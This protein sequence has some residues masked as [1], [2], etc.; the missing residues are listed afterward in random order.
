MTKS[1]TDAMMREC[2]LDLMKKAL[3]GALYAESAWKILEHSRTARNPE[4]TSVMHP[5]RLIHAKF[6]DMMIAKLR[7]KSL[8]LVE[9]LPFDKKIREC[10]YDWPMIGYTMVGTKRLGNVQRCFAD[11]IERGVPGDLAETGAWRG[12]MTIFMRALLKAYGDTDRKVWV[13]DSFEGLPAP[14]NS[15]D[16]WDLSRVRQLKVSLE[17][18]KANFERFG[19]LDEQVEFVKG[20]FCDSLPKAPIEKLAILRLDGDLY[21]STMDALENL[22]PKVSKGGYVIIDDYFSW[23]A[24]KQAVTDYCAK[25]SLQ[26]KIE[27]IEG[28]LGAYWKVA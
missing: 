21:H 1:P 27:E 4:K 22:F 10:G 20:W 16:G 17:D 24:C 23:A 8:L 28:R 18:V 6:R 3:T 7:K 15:E 11:V 25:H 14:K 12:G 9:A 13:A 2:Y 5:F 26:P 19:L